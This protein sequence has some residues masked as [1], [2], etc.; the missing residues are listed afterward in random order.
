MKQITHICLIMLLIASGCKKE[1][2]VL[3]TTNTTTINNCDSYSWPANGITY[4]SSGVYSVV[5]TN[6]AGCA[7][8]SILNLTINN[9]NTSTAVESACDSYLWSA[10]GQNYNQ[11]GVYNWV[12]T[13]SS[14]CDSTAVLDL[15][16]N[17]SSSYTN[18][19]SIC[20]GETVAVGFN[21]YNLSGVY[22]D[23]FTSNNGCDS[24]VTTNLTVVTQITAFIFQTGVSDIKVN[25]LGGN[26]P[27]SY[28][29]NTGETTQT[30]TPLADG[31]YW[32]I[33][34]DVNTCESDSAF[35]TVNWI[36]TFIAEININKLSIYPNPSND[37]FNIVFNSNTKQDID[38]KIHNVLGE[39]IFS[40]T[41]T[42]F[43]GDYNRTVDMTPYPNAIYILQ[44][45]TNDGML[46]KKLV[47]EK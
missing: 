13:N 30:I 1:E 19:V 40:E 47:L 4:N 35:F 36:S 8:T 15:T 25:T 5:S 37:V 27:Y 31:D 26:T 45:N 3:T 33:I 43:S 7:D 42:E 22:Y 18:T 11:S 24:T 20:F 9:S 41:L 32:V 6:S 44:L 34:T 2:D 23:E 39:V 16:I 46:N 17:N 14:G 38:L 10:N 21:N 28:Q 12:T 29:W